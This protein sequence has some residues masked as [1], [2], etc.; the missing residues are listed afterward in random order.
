MDRSRE[1]N[2]QSKSYIQVLV[3]EGYMVDYGSQVAHG[4]WSELEAQQSP[5]RQGLRVVRMVLRSFASQQQNECI[6]WF[7]DN[8]NVVRIIMHG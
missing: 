2:W 8:Q 7:T 4:Q 6:F 3:V 5:M 1:A